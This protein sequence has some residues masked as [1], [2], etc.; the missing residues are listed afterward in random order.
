LSPK[1]PVRWRKLS[2]N[3]PNRALRCWRS[4]LTFNR[5]CS[6]S[7]VSTR[8]IACA[9]D[10]PQKQIQK[11]A[12]AK[13]CLSIGVM[14]GALTNKKQTNLGLGSEWAYLYVGNWETNILMAG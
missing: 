10:A 1:M 8:M 6:Y 5:C 7:V 14:F 2:S 9:C 11:M 3:R 13:T 12:M 4:S